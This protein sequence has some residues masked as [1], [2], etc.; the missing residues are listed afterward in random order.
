MEDTELVRMSDSYMK[1]EEERLDAALR[2]VQYEL[3]TPA[4]VSLITGAGR[5]ER[6]SDVRVCSHHI[7]K[8]HS[9]ARNL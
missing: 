3:D 7:G 9:R 1:G 8:S 2:S 4:T 6:V 5:I